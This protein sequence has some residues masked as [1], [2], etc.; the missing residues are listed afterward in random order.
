M[1]DKLHETANLPPPTPPSNAPLT[2]KDDLVDEEELAR[3][4]V[5]RLSLSNEE[6]LKIAAKYPPPP[7]Y[8]EGDEE[9]PFDP[10]EE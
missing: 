1:S 5:A 9:M 6:L 10:I 2:P 8:F 7:E 3:Q 4:E